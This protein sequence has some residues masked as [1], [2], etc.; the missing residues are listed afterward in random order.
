MNIRNL[1]IASL[2][3]GLISLVLVNTPFLNLINL[4][5]CIGFWAGPIAAVWLYRRLSGELTLGEAAVIGML[6]GAWH[7]LIGVLLS[8]L[9]LAGVQ[10]LLQTAQIVVPAADTADLEPALSGLGTVLF[11]LIGV[12][13]DVVFGLLGGM[14][15]GLLFGRR[16]AGA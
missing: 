14:V 1:L 16:R 15:G 8:P 3:G 9:G 2:M 13:F 11:N 10:G 6:A 5:A 7:G 12:L 4:L